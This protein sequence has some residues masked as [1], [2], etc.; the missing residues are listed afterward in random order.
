MVMFYGYVLLFFCSSFSKCPPLRFD[1]D[2]QNSNAWKPEIP[3][4]NTIVLGQ[5]HFVTN[6]QGTL[7]A[8]FPSAQKISP[9]PR[10]IGVLASHCIAAEDQ[11]SHCQGRGRNGRAEWCE[12][13]KSTR[14]E[15][16]YWV[17]VKSL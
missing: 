17:S 13:P 2:S 6:F 15:R 4:K 1:I 14:L 12:N 5:V 11:Q 7:P 3:F 8:E 10:G 16:A 9:M